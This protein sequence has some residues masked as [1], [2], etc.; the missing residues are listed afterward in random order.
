LD[1]RG[2]FN[3]GLRGISEGDIHY[4]AS[5]GYELEVGG[6]RVWSAY[7]NR[8]PSQLFYR[9]E[10]NHSPYPR[11]SL[12]KIEINR[13]GASLSFK[14]QPIKVSLE[15]T[16]INNWILFEADGSLTVSDNINLVSFQAQT[17]F[18][19][20]AWHVD[21]NVRLQ[22]P[23]KS[24]LGL[25]KFLGM[26]AVYYQTPL[27]ENALVMNI[28]MNARYW[29]KYK[30]LKYTPYSG[31][32]AQDGTELDTYPIVDVFANFQIKRVSVYV[33]TEHLSQGLGGNIWSS[34]LCGSS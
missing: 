30:T 31:Q 12:P 1:L 3:L 2:E 19:F 15:N 28:G 13:I 29:S 32:F 34:L 16:N 5:L 20:G 9:H 17:N 26:A 21:S 27:F 6:L 8:R 25:P 11:T 10:S 22:N 23:S 4:R 14:R 24:V 18:N 7:S 33:R